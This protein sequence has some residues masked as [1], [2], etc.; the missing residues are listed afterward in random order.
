MAPEVMAM[1]ALKDHESLAL[2]DVALVR[3][4]LG[5]RPGD[6]ERELRDIEAIKSAAGLLPGD[7]ART[8]ARPGGRESVASWLAE[9]MRCVALQ[10]AL[11]GR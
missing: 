5:L 2:L 7:F 8:L 6:D 10:R 3:D 1:L 4:V 9:A 11:A